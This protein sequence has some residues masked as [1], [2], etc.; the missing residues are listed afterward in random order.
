[1]NVQISLHD[2][3]VRS[4]KIGQKLCGCVYFWQFWI[5]YLTFEMARFR[6]QDCYRVCLYWLICFGINWIFSGLMM[7]II[8]E[9]LRWRSAS[10]N[11]S[12]GCI[13]K[14]GYWSGNVGVWQ[15]FPNCGHL[16]YCSNKQQQKTTIKTYWHCT[17]NLT[18]CSPTTNRSIQCWFWRPPPRFHRPRQQKIGELWLDKT[19]QLLSKEK[20]GWSVSR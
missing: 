5:L 6:G 19:M 17:Q 18:E 20:R 7:F 1:M 2:S 15:L 8:A 9:M 3:W 16:R 14:I 11:L 4:Q 12:H 10:P 13:I